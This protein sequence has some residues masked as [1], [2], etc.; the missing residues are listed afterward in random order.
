MRRHRSD[1]RGRMTLRSLSRQ[2]GAVAHDVGLLDLLSEFIDANA[3]TVDLMTGQHRTELPEV[4]ILVTRS[5]SNPDKLIEW[6]AHCEYLRAL[7]RLG[8]ETLARQD[9]RMLAPPLAL[10]LVSEL[11]SALTRGWTAALLIIRSPARAAQTLHPRSNRP[12][13]SAHSRASS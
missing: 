4:G 12:T 2:A 5:P 7:Q 8:H 10:A 6:S 11:N 13:A 3:D 9:Q 1:D